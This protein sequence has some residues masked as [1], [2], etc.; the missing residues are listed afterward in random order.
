MYIRLASKIAPGTRTDTTQPNPGTTTVALFLRAH[1]SVA[2]APT[3]CNPQS[4]PHNLRPSNAG[5]ALD[6]TILQP[7]PQLRC[8]IVSECSS[9][10]PRI[11]IERATRSP[12]P[13]L[14]VLCSLLAAHC[15]L[16]IAGLSYLQYTCLSFW[17]VLPAC[18]V[19]WR[20]WGSPAL[21]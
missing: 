14:F 16:L 10:V 21:T 3:I 13:L 6:P 19:V 9:S 12:P 11:E 18:P 15:S 1:W 5:V 4:N 7:G 20:A 17:P 2:V 8:F